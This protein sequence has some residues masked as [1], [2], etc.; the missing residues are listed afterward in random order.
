MTSKHSSN[1]PLSATFDYYLENEIFPCKRAELRSWNCFKYFHHVVTT[2]QNYRS[3]PSGH[4]LW[5]SGGGKVQMLSV[6][7]PRTGLRCVLELALYQ[8]EMSDGTID[9]LIMTN[10]TSSI[11]AEKPGN[12][13]A[14]YVIILPFLPLPKGYFR[15]RCTT[16]E[17]IVRR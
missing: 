6:A 10:N 13:H 7:I 3:L 8:V 1:N 11:A 2:V 5:F 15:S 17:N 16:I 9:L 4:F 14:K 12:N